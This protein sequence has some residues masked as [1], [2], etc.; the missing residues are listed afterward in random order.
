MDDHEKAWRELDMDAYINVLHDQVD[1]LYSM[2][3][4]DYEKEFVTALDESSVLETMPQFTDG[5]LRGWNVY[6]RLDGDPV[7]ID[8]FDTEEEGVKL[9]R[10]LRAAIE[11]KEPC[12]DLPYE[13]GEEQC[14]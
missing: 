4:F 6:S 10:Q 11:A 7:L 14:H 9:I 3:V 8:T 12:F 1:I 2:L 13:K 5:T